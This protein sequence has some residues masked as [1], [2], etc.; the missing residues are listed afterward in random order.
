MPPSGKNLVDLVENFRQQ[1]ENALAHERRLHVEAAAAQLLTLQRLE[2]ERGRRRSSEGLVV[3]DE[4][5]KVAPADSGGGGSP[6]NIRNHSSQSDFSS[7]ASFNDDLH[8][9]HVHFEES[10]H[11]LAPPTHAFA[12]SSMFQS[13]THDQSRRM[14]SPS[15]RGDTSVMHYADAGL[16]MELRGLL[17]GMDQSFTGSLVPVDEGAASILDMRTDQ[18]V[19]TC[20]CVVKC[21]SLYVL[22]SHDFLINTTKT[23]YLLLDRYHSGAAHIQRQRRNMQH[24][25]RH[26][27]S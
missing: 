12:H 5:V 7:M 6:G 15:R 2:T 4:H 9:P 24:E 11:S 10:A 1:Q 26:E 17:D 20:C 3:I 14:S 19:S 18:Q 16:S 23:Q 8:H 22:I 27:L 13:R 21:T 25:S